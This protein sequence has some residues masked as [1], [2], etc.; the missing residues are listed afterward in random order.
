MRSKTIPKGMTQAN[1][2]RIEIRAPRIFQFSASRSANLRG[3]AGERLIDGLLDERA[4][5]RIVEHSDRPAENS[6]AAIGELCAAATGS[7]VHDDLT[8]GGVVLALAVEPRFMWFGALLSRIFNS[9]QP[10]PL[11]GP[12]PTST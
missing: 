11:T 12:I 7:Q 4:R 5:E 10:D 6:G 3:E 2:Y 8:L 9:P 1:H